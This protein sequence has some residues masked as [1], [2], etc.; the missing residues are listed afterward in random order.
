MAEIWTKC[1]LFVFR[2]YAQLL[3]VFWEMSSRP[4]SSSTMILELYCGRKMTHPTNYN[5]AWHSIRNP[6]PNTPWTN[7]YHLQN[8]ANEGRCVAE[9]VSDNYC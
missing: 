3:T 1:I 6:P 9:F 2:F 5:N 7:T 8:D 4:T